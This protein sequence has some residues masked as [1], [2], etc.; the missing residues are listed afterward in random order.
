[1]TEEHRKKKKKAS[2][3]RRKKKRK[4]K[5]IMGIIM[6][7][8]KDEVEGSESLVLCDGEKTREVEKVKVVKKA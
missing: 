2:K 8:M 3:R 6:R 1:V 4:K 5:V 7:M